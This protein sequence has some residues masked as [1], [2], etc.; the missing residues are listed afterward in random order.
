M[1]WVKNSA[2]QSP[3]HKNHQYNLYPCWQCLQES[4][5]MPGGSVVNFFDIA[6]AAHTHKKKTCF[7]ANSDVPA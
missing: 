5:L 4:D 7:L 1:V 6:C 2:D 3:I